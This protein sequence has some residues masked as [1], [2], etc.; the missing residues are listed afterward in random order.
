[1]ATALLKLRKRAGYRE[2]RRS[3]RRDHESPKM[4]P[5][6][7]WAE[8]HTFA[9]ARVHHPTT[10]DAVRR[11][12][13]GS[14]R[15]HAVGA[16]HSFNGIADTPG[17]LIDLSKMPPDIVVDPE[18]QTATVGAGTNYGVVARALHAAGWALHNMASLPHVS[19]AG[20]IMTGTHGSGDRLGNLATA[21]RALELVAATGDLVTLRSGDPGFDGAVVS[22]GALGVVTR[23]TLAVEPAFD[24]RQD[25][26]E[27]LRWK[28]VL[29]DFDAVMSA[30]YSVSLMTTWSEPFVSRFWVKTR[31]SE[32]DAEARPALRFGLR[33]AV[34]PVAKAAPEAMQRLNPFGVRGAWFERLPHFRPEV[35]PG[36]PGHLQSEYV[37][38]RAKVRQ[39]IE[40]LR[41]RGERIDRHLWITEIRSVAKDE[42]WLSPSYG[43]DR[44]GIHFSWLRQ[45]EAVDELTAEIEAMLLPLDA[46]PHWGKIVHAGAGELAQ[47]YPKML[48]FRKLARAYDPVGKF[49]NEFLNKHVFG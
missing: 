30:G 5:L 48:A 26:F 39:A 43:D 7:N 14:R 35:V 8:N 6:Q 25:A 33:P 24:M 20:A 12:V 36:P 16:R 37:L 45:P 21:V 40:Q 22:L 9:A 10:I 49:A 27:G 28:T 44:V 4:T 2:T 15:V 31:L 13:A 3:P 32:K 18:Q 47:R 46:R 1:V 34:E 17:D 42:L 19:V 38:P 29:A 11:A 23:V 41:A